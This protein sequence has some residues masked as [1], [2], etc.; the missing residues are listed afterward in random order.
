[1]TTNTRVNAIVSIV[2]PFTAGETGYFQIGDK[3][4]IE[5][6]N[7]LSHMTV[8]TISGLIHRGE[9][10]TPLALVQWLENAPPVRIGINKLVR[11]K[12]V[13]FWMVVADCDCTDFVREE[14]RDRLRDGTLAPAKKFFERSAALEAAQSLGRR[15][16]RNYILLEATEFTCAEEQHT[17]GKI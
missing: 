2:A 16:N 5:D 7:S 10:T 4:R 12:P 8:G 15:F 11:L 6:Q 9:E 3:V 13:K 17:V 14:S 1:M